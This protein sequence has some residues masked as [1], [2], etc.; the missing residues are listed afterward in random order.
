MDTTRITKCRRTYLTALVALGLA[1]VFAASFTTP[2][3]ADDDHYYEHRHHDHGH[4]YGYGR[5]YD[6]DRYER[7]PAYRSYDYEDRDYYSYGPPPVVYAP[8]PP[9]AVEFVFPLR[10]H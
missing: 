1:S 6:N 8:Y 7:R 5:D 9:P 2:A 4:H 3:K 10:F